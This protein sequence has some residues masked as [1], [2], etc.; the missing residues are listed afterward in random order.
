MTLEK[1]QL[2][3]TLYVIAALPDDADE[4]YMP[5]MEEGLTLVSLSDAEQN[6]FMP[7]WS[8][9]DALTLWLHDFHVKA[10][11]VEMSREVLLGL[12]SEAPCQYL[13]LD[14]TPGQD[15]FPPNQIYDIPPAG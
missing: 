15:S 8:S 9:E 4:D 2:P 13:V 7:V 12:V 5:S 1:S 6:E 11:S 10:I 14:L 3:E